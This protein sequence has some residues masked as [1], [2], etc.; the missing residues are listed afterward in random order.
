MPASALNLTIEQGVTLAQA[1]TGLSAY[2]GRTPTAVVR[3]RFGG[4]L[5]AT[6][7]CTEVADGSTTVGLSATLSAA[8]SAPAYAKDTE[9]SV[10]IGYWEMIDTNGETKTRI[11]EG[12]V[13]LSRQ[14]SA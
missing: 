2:N 1:V 10:V 4:R 9:R 12:T 13:T 5:L 7:T 14:V 3:D 8:L 6:L 11:K